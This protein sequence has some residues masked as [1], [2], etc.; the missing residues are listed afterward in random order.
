MSTFTKAPASLAFAKM[1]RSRSFTARIE[2][3]QSMGSMS[4]KSEVSLTERLTRGIAPSG[5]RSSWSTAAH[6]GAAAISA[7]R[8]SR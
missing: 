1:G 3:S 8:I 6:A 4:E 2:P 7:S 5:P